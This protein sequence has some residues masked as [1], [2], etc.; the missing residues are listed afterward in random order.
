MKMVTSQTMEEFNRLSDLDNVV[1]LSNHT[2][3]D[4]EKSVLKNGLK[5]CPTPGEPHMGE[6]RRDLARFHRSSRLKFHFG[7]DHN[8]TVRDTSIGPFNNTRDLKLKE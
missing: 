5:F 6:T 8:Q 1:N 3:S 7:K 2:L 4:D